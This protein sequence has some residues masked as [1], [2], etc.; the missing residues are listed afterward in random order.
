MLICVNPA[1][2]H[3][4]NPGV[5]SV[6]NACGRSLRLADRY[7]CL[8]IIGQGGFGRTFLAH[9][10]QC[11]PPRRCVIKQSLPP[12]G[13]DD[14]HQRFY[15][16][17]KRL[18]QLG[19]HPQI[20]RLWAVFEQWGEQYLVQEYIEGPNLDQQLKQQP[21]QEEQVQTLLMSLLP[22]LK[23]IHQQQ[24]IHRDIKPANIIWRPPDKPFLVDFGAAKAVLDPRLLQQTATIIGTAGYAAPE[25]TLGKAVFASDIYSLGVVSI[26]ALTG[27]HPFD[28]YSVSEDR[29]CWRS[30]VQTPIQLSLARIL[31]RM[32]ARGLRERY[33][34]AA[35][36]L[37]D[38]TW[39]APARTLDAAGSI[40]FSPKVS[41]GWKQQWVIRP[42][43][44][45]TALA[46]SPNG[47]ALATGGADR[48]VR[49]WDLATGELIQSFTRR[50]GLL[51]NGHQDEVVAV[52][53]SP[54]GR[55]LIS[56]S[57][58]GSILTWDLSHYRQVQALAEPNWEV[59][60]L[61]LSPTGNLLV[62]GSGA[63][64]IHIWD[65]GAGQIR[66]VLALHQDRITSLSVSP[67]GKW[68]ISGSCDRT[69]RLWA[70]PSGRLIKTFPPAKT[71]ITAVAYHAPTQ[72]ILSA[73]AQGAIQLWRPQQSPRQF[74]Q[75][76]GPINH[77]TL[78]PDGSWLAAA[79]ETGVVQVWS[80]G[81]KRF[82]EVLTHGWSVLTLCFSPDSRTL[83]SS[84][85]D[86][87]VY[88]WVKA[89]P[90]D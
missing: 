56:A 64:K 24:V 69:V 83:V 60:A 65:R 78:S 32:I 84:S 62:S 1:C 22:V 44:V 74:A 6:C 18:Q 2:D 28:L 81:P 27:L 70:L 68:L 5:A 34:S 14:G 7:Q 19:K 90:V 30:F 39:T 16:E 86:E 43:T 88:R 54:D 52:V 17:A 36:V 8:E 80:L 26:H 9:D 40:V 4:R 61:A 38:L 23:F 15:Q 37:A 79:V 13:V 59:T 89:T 57:R 48:S 29:W 75:A 35:E 76:Q 55:E 49:L 45:S 82:A 33:G 42:G 77:L 25:Q 51:G 20:P 10:I 53:F 3:P 47:R 50:L 58:D 67:D 63:G 85:R 31:D 71:T 72:Q 12:A 46:V 73:N 66:A 21:F 41:P 87:M 11:D